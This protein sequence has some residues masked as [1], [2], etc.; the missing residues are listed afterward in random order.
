MEQGSFVRHRARPEW[1]I[2]RVLLVAGHYIIDFEVRGLIKLAAAVA[3]FQLMVV[4]DAEVP[5]EHPLRGGKKPGAF[6]STAR[7]AP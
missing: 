5:P 7:R 3:D 1:G 6:R 4:D 2:G